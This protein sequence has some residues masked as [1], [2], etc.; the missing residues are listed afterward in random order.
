MYF[1][2]FSSVPGVYYA[3]QNSDTVGKAIVLL[4]LLGSVT[5]WT[6]ML[7]KGF[8]LHRAKNQSKRFLAMFKSNTRNLATPG[9][10]REGMGDS[11]PRGAIY[12]AGVEKLLEFYED[13][14]RGTINF[15]GSPVTPVKLSAAQFDAIE[16][17]LERA[18]SHQ[19]QELE[20]RIGFIFCRR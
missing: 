1:L 14:S 13:G 16:A 6:T 4:L 15:A 18:V 7:D 9:L 10:V 5:T 19:I 8:S 12:S 3:Y 2:L 17:V 11:G 20:K